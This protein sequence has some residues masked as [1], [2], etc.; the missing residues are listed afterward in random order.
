MTPA[1]RT[2]RTLN[3]LAT[4]SLALGLTAGAWHPYYVVPGLIGAAA[5]YSVAASYRGEDHRI[6]ARHRRLS[7]AALDDEIAMALSK[8]CCRF[9]ET[10]DGAHQP[11]CRNHTRSAA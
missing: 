6:R 11:H 4:L 1:Q 2:A 5:L 8:P 9:W 7:L 10:R 3:A